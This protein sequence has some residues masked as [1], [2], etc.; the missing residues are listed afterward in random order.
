MKS[1]LYI[2]SFAIFSLASFAVVG[3]GADG[4]SL[5]GERAQKEQDKAAKFFNSLK[6]DSVFLEIFG[7][8][9]TWKAIKDEVAL[10]LIGTQ[11]QN[12]AGVQGMD[13]V[14]RNLYTMGVSSVIRRYIKAAVFAHEAQLAE[15]KVDPSIAQTIVS[16]SISR[17]RKQC[18]SKPNFLSVTND[19]RSYFSFA[20]TNSILANA[21][22]EQVIKPSIKVLPQDI[23]Q[24]R[25]RR[26]KYNL[27]VPATNAL[28]CAEMRELRQKIVSGVK[29]FGEAA[30]EVSD[31]GSSVEG[32][33]WGTFSRD[34]IAPALSKI[35]FS[36]PLNQLS[37]VIE[38]PKSFDILKVTS[39]EYD[40]DENGKPITNVI[41][42]VNISHIMR[43]KAIPYP[44]VKDDQLAN[45]IFNVHL[46]KALRKREREFIGKYA[47]DIK[48]IVPL[49][50]RKTGRKKSK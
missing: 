48:C 28:I 32:G 9:L 13:N 22:V 25:E 45:D 34:E 47:K 14:E 38:T 44:D 40:E 39:Y 36:I 19:S 41:D 42:K 20:L 37:E 1:A 15:V 49:F 7:Q 33:V 21:Y 8:Q 4:L 17:L 24:E 3:K 16:N 31:C 43:D 12:I 26:Q 29:D 46:K 27:S 6:E 50:D 11:L 23:A 35:A 30:E 5:I 18:N 2:I 10:R